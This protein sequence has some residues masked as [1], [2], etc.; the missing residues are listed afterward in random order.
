MP[1]YSFKERFVPFVLEGSKPHTIRQRRNQTVQPG[2][3]L[4]LYYGMRT[5]YCRKL[6]EEICT[7]VRTIQIMKSGKVFIC[8]KRLDGHQ[9]LY[10]INKKYKPAGR[11]L[12]ESEKDK[13]AWLDGFRPDGSTLQKPKDCFD[14]MIRFWKQTHKL[15]FTGDIIYWEPQK[16]NNEQIKN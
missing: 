10:F 5:K 7:D 11:Y 9:F 3:T 13:L 1:A 4:Y 16:I 15:A 8:D 14:L 12:S 6:R 2:V